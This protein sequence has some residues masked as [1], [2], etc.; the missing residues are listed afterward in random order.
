MPTIDQAAPQGSNCFTLEMRPPHN[1]SGAGIWLVIAA[2][3]LAAIPLGG[4]FLT[5]GAWPIA[6]FYGLDLVVLAVALIMARHKARR[7]ERVV[8]T[9]ANTTI[10]HGNH[11]G[12]QGSARLDTPWLS[13]RLHDPQ[14]HHCRIE[15]SCK[16][17]R[18]IIGGFLAPSERREVA[19][20]LRDELGHLMGHTAPHRGPG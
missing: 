13:I 6:G 3:C 9:P 20:I 18:I 2:Y 5:L 4:F 1:L 17:K 7:Y 8:M 19:N 16:G 14:A 10:E 12:C 11:Q 15:L